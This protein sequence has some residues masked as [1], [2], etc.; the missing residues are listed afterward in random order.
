MNPTFFSYVFLFL[1]ATSTA[2]ADWLNFRGP[3]ASGYAP[4]AGDV[5]TELSR[6]SLAWEIELPGRGLGS[7][8]VVGDKVVVTAASGPEEKMLHILCFSAESGKPLWERRFWATGRTMTQKKTCVA[9]PTPAS[10]GKRIFALFSSND[11]FCLDLDGKLQWMRGLTLDYPNASN[12]LGMASSP[13]VAG[14]VLVAQIENDSESFAA[15]FDL[16]SGRN[17]WKIDRP[18]AANWTSPTLLEIDGQPVAALQSSKGV[19]GLAP[20]TGSE[21]FRYEGGASTIPSSAAAGDTLYV[22]SKGLT[23]LRAD[24]SAPEAEKLWNEPGQRPGTASPLVIGDRVHVINGAGVLSCADRT[25]G[26]RLWRM[27]LKG[28]IS[29]SPIAAGNGH[30]Y[31][32]SET[33]VGQCVA[34]GEDQGEVVSAI[35]LG[36]T[37]LG[38]PSLS[39]GALYV[40][41]DGKL[42]KFG[43]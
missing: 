9:A 34:L 25:S 31:V 26:E 23:A 36:E 43:E 42:W 29:S 38:T 10:D 32:F 1:L 39:D 7:P 28:P 2:S 33:G 6:E 4:G 19:L 24:G 15:G 8:L 35:E 21:L 13:L 18:K 16:D 37:I 17:L 40:R 12:S 14:G 22:P 20:A 41:S 30:L 27:R 5:P 3:G 11:L